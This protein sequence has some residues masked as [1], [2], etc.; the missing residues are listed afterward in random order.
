MTDGAMTS[1]AVTD[2]VA[3]IVNPVAHDVMEVVARRWSPR[4]FSER[5]VPPEALLSLFEAARWAAS[6]NNEQPWRFVV[7]TRDDPDAF[8][9]MLA[10]LKESNRSWAQRAPVLVL[11]LASA[12]Y[13]RSGGANKHAWYD[14]GQA[15]AQL[16]LQAT[17]LGLYAHQMGGIYPEVAAETYGV[18]EGV[19]V[20]CAVAV[21]YLGDPA[22][23]PEDLR[24]RERRPRARKPLGELV[25][26]GR[27]GEAAR[28]EESI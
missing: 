5:P 11:V 3:Q 14:T 19:D 18:P 8:A 22:Q 20:V 7:A 26:A 17:D 1:E 4:A 25:F 16:V 13:A 21:G 28:L 12:R 2:G 10:C 23:L 27:F 9:R 6:S 15:V 24:E